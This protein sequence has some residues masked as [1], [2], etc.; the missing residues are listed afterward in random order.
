MAIFDILEKAC[1]LTGFLFDRCG[2]VMGSPMLFNFNQSLHFFLSRSQYAVDF[3]DRP[4][5]WSAMKSRAHIHMVVNPLAVVCRFYES[6]VDRRIE[7]C[8]NGRI[9]HSLIFNGRFDC[10]KAAV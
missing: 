5:F 3:G 7:I 1:H 8:Y 9:C 4:S 2:K 6:Q 10:I